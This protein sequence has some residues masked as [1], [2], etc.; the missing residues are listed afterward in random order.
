MKLK[1]ET[2]AA[3]AAVTAAGIFAVCSALVALFPE[4]AAG[5]WKNAWHLGPTGSSLSV[6]WTS[7]VIG[8][9]FWAIAS[10]VVFAVAGWVYTR[11]SGYGRG[12]RWAAPVPGR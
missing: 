12:Q 11:L 1:T 4:L 2:L 10:F 9:C 5:V 8:L 6:S 7:F 3:S